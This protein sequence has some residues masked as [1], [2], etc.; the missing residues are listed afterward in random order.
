MARWVSPEQPWAFAF[1][2]AAILAPTDAALGQAVVA[3]EAVPEDLR[4]AIAVESGLND[5]LALPIVIMAA[6]T[7]AEMVG[8]MRDGAP[9]DILTF[10]IAQITLGPLAGLAIGFAAAKLR[11]FAIAR[12]SWRR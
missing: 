6:L 2:G 11:D 5:G 12:G 3:D 1:L 10:G 4:E 9:D 7:T 8:G